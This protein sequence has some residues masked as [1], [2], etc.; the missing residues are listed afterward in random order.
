MKKLRRMLF[1]SIIA[2]LLCFITLGTSTYAWFS[3]NQKVSVTGM[4]VTTAVNDNLFIA[5]STASNNKLADADFRNAL[6]YTAEAA[7]LQPVSTVDANN[8]YYTNEAAADGHKV[9]GNYT[10]LANNDILVNSTHYQGYADYVFELKAINANDTNEYVNLT[11]LNIL[12]EGDVT[13]VTHAFR[14]AIFVQANTSAFDD[15]TDEQKA[16]AYTG[17]YDA[18]GAVNSIFA[19]SDYAYFTTGKAVSATDALAAVS[20]IN[21]AVSLLVPANTT[22]YFKVTVR[23][24]LEGEDTDCY[25]TK[26]VNLTSQWALDLA[27]ELQAN[28]TAAVAVLSAAA[29][30]TIASDGT[31]LTA[32]LVNTL[33]ETAS[34]YAWYK[35]G[36]AA[37]VATTE[38]YAPADTDKYY[39]V[40]TTVKGNEY[41]TPA[42]T[43]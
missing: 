8:F 2:C 14:V 13:K 31:T 17:A 38:T 1:S 9:S 6:H 36:Q 18:I 33:G 28:N 20:N 26:F 3:M 19:K 30:A 10:A 5:Q 42:I 43:K 23:I 35:V 21:T 12:Y 25:N 11:K 34:T 41:R 32:T 15:L 40:I 27:F 24:W 22:K 7:K 16:T 29:N 37:A 4:A 39:C